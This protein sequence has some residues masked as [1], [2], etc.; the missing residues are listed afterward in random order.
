MRLKCR[1]YRSE[2]ADGIAKKRRKHERE[3]QIP[4]E[5]WLKVFEIYNNDW[6]SEQISVVLKLQSICVS[7]VTIY[8]R[9]YAE[10]LAGQLKS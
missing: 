8:R 9:I 2:T 1:E 7:H 5:I 6:S 3:P 4:M 10:I